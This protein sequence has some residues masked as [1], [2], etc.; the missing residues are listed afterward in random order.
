[1]G[2]AGGALPS[3]TSLVRAARA[4]QGSVTWVTRQRRLVKH[5][6]PVETGDHLLETFGV[7]RGAHLEDVQPVWLHVAALLVGVTLGAKVQESGGDR[8]RGVVTPPGPDLHCGR[9]G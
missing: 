6:R 5:L 9:F 1:V 8:E 2:E 7:A 4:P 3:G